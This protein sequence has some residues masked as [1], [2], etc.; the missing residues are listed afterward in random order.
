MHTSAEWSRLFGRD[1]GFRCR[2]LHHLRP[3]EQRVLGS[4]YMHP[5]VANAAK[6]I[7]PSLSH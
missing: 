4:G 3:A 7:R 6:S 1:G 2:E 5:S